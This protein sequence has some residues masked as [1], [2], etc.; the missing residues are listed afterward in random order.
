MDWLSLWGSIRCEQRTALDVLLP[1]FD[2]VSLH[3]TFV[4]RSVHTK[5]TSVPVMVTISYQR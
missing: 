1:L 2:D 3:Y 4:K 5:R